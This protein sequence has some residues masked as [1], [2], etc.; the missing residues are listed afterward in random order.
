MKSIEHLSLIDDFRIGKSIKHL[1][2][3]V[4][5]NN[6]LDDQDRFHLIQSV[7]YLNLY[8]ENLTPWEMIRPE[9]DN[10]AFR[11]CDQY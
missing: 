5:D 8:R 9:S 11:T 1:I 2:S 4:E 7:Y 10:K 3:F 6:W